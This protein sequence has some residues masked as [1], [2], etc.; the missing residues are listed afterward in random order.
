MGG[1]IDRWIDGWMGGW[2]DGGV[3]VLKI[4]PLGF[5]QKQ[6]RDDS[7]MSERFASYEQ[8]TSKFRKFSILPFESVRTDKIVSVR[9]GMLSHTVAAA[10]KINE[11]RS[12]SYFHQSCG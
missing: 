11:N 12:F 4:L 10:L 8:A 7:R 5:Y 6:K 1:W 2:M 3:A 9:P